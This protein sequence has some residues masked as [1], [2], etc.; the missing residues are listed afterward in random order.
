MTYYIAELDEAHGIAAIWI[1]EK[2]ARGPSVFDPSKHIFDTDK[3][4]G[5]I[6]APKAKIENWI[7]RATRSAQRPLNT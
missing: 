5:F 1:K 2:G 3:T 4:S 7:A 6:G